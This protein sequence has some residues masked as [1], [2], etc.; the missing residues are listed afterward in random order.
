M[1][2]LAADYGADI[3]YTE[4]MIDKRCGERR[5]QRRVCSRRP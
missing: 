4:E 2:M 5:L 1:R 3:V